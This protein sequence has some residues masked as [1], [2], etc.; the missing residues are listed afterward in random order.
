MKTIIS[1]FISICFLLQP[2]Q[3]QNFISLPPVLHEL[4]ISR[5]DINPNQSTFDATDPNSASGGRI[6]ALASSSDNQVFFAATEWGGVYSSTDG[7]RTWNHVS[8][9]LPLV[10]WDVDIDPSDKNKIYAT[11]WYDGR[12]NSLSGISISRDGGRSWSNPPTSRT[13]GIPCNQD[14]IDAPS[15]FG[16]AIDPTDSKHVAIGTNC[17]L[18]ISNDG[19]ESWTFVDPTPTDSADD[20][21]DVIIH[22]GGIIDLVGDDG[23]F[24]TTDD[25]LNWSTVTS[26]LGIPSGRTSIAVSPQEPN[27]LF[28]TDG[29]LIYQSLDGGASWPTSLQ[30]TPP[31]NGNRIPFVAT[32]PT[33]GSSYDLWYG[34]VGLYRTACNTLAANDARSR[35]PGN[36]WSSDLS[37]ARGGHNDAGDILFDQTVQTNACPLLFASDGGVYYN[38]RTG[39]NCQTPSWEQPDRSPHALWLFSM[40]GVNRSG[41]NP[42]DL[43]FGTQ[44]NGVFA[45]TT[46][47]QGTVSWEG[48]ACCDGFDIEAAANRVVWTVCCG[49][50]VRNSNQGMDNGIGRM[51]ITAAGFGNRDQNFRFIDKLA[52]YG[53][54]NFVFLTSVGA[55]ITTNIDQQTPS[56]TLLDTTTAPS[57]MRGVIV[58][59]FGQNPTFTVMAASGF[60]G[61]IYYSQNTLWQYQGTNP[62]GTW[63]QISPPGNVGGF[64]IFDVDPGNPNRIIASHINGSTVQMVITS[65]G[66][67]TWRTLPALDRMMTDNGKFRYASNRSPRLWTSLGFGV[68]PTLVKFDPSDPEIIVAGAANAG[69]CISINGGFSWHRLTNPARGARHIPRPHFVH[70]DHRPKTDRQQTHNLMLYVGTQGR[71]VW[72]LSFRRKRK[73]INPCLTNPDQCLLTKLYPG[74][75]ELPPCLN[76]PCI[77]IDPIEN[78]CQIKY[79]CPGCES[80]SLCPP[81]YHFFLDDL[82]PRIWQAGIFDPKGN[83]VDFETRKEKNT[84]ILS[85]RPDEERWNEQRGIEDYYL[86]FFSVG[87]RK[88]RKMS[89]R[90]RLEVSDSKYKGGKILPF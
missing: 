32:N 2:L 37:K 12:V 88:T 24:R 56:W 16:I 52:Q 13:P 89:I 28:V 83:M 82:N 20:I 4:K 44:D 39:N 5:T 72:R 47:G 85:F 71:G 3:S 49:E 33:G 61:G 65:D 87:K 80:T 73:S 7:G 41:K 75:I 30:I 38:T 22:D 58:S 11:S 40:D 15:A 27:V 29:S 67:T 78:N 77:A 43:Y 17:G 26:G 8:K 9:H 25:G 62:N 63:T 19:G 70:I 1:I 23:H 10:S 18:A 74:I 50:S 59:N 64:G 42:E 46:A 53:S 51:T 48:K 69:L 66:G 57:Q 6:H 79:N 76:P 21:W 84:I 35:V 45:T 68:Q 55:F 36:A 86:G 81:Y 34:A 31:D 60:A 14:R 90:T 54:N